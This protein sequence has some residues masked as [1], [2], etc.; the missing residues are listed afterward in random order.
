MSDRQVQINLVENQLHNEAV[1]IRAHHLRNLIHSRDRAALCLRFEDLIVDFTRQPLTQDI[2]QKL[3]EL[4]E[5]KSLPNY[6]E[7]LFTGEVINLTECQPVNHCEQR[8][9]E[10]QNTMDYKKLVS[11]ADAVRAN[12]NFKSIVNKSGLK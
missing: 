6:M 9:P 8:A 7:E 4:A 11:F 2:L 12:K 5:V 1:K 3:M 10:H